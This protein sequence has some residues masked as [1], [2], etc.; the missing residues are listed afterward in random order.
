MEKVDS[1]VWID[2]PAS[3]RLK[4]NAST[5]VQEKNVRIDA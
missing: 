4:D 2:A 5:K 3:E 1:K